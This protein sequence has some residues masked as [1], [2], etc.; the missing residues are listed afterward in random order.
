MEQ[1][2]KAINE[3]IEV[4][5]QLHRYVEYAEST[6]GNS[7]DMFKYRHQIIIDDLKREV[8]ELKRAKEKLQE[9]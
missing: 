7:N 4:K 3:R 6:L 9:L 2:I 8:A 1:A 5:L